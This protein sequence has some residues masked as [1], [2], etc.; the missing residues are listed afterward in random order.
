MEAGKADEAVVERKLRRTL[1]KEAPGLASMADAALG[2]K[3]ASLAAWIAVLLT[4]LMP[5][6]SGEQKQLSP[7]EVARIIYQVQKEAPADEGRPS[8]TGPLPTIQSSEPEEPA[9]AESK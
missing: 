2:T 4:I 3:G 1:D 9:G 8:K 6:F 7:E 5:L